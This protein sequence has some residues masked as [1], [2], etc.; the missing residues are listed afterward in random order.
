MKTIKKSI[1]IDNSKEKVW[2][3]LTKDRYTRDWLAVF[4]PGSHA[5]TDWQLNSKVV[6]ADD[7]G[8]GIIGR[9]T[10]HDPYELLS[11]EYYG[12]LINNI[13]DFESEE[14]KT[15]KGARETYRLSQKDK[16]TVL[17]IES[18]MSENGFES[19][20][21]AWDEALLRIKHL[22]EKA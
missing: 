17:D 12:V 21:S 4:S 5:L 22:A 20:S 11:M 8:S 18:D 13:E 2:D 16:K 19:M 10:I 1:E 7:S 9:I 6:F 15:F 14:A 3:V